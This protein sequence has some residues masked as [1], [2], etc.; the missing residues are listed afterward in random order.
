MAQ[1]VNS[2]NKRRLYKK[3]SFLVRPNMI[4]KPV[5]DLSLAHQ[6][7]AWVGTGTVSLSLPHGASVDV[8]SWPGMA[9]CRQRGGSG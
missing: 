9:T 6:N 4:L 8:V 3:T 5:S 7:L 2:E 1:V